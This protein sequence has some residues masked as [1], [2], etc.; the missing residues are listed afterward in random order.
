[1]LQGIAV[2][3]NALAI[4]EFIIQVLHPPAPPAFQMPSLPAP[5]IGRTQELETLATMPLNDAPVVLTPANYS[6]IKRRGQ[7][8]A[9]SDL[10][11]PVSAALS[12]VVCSGSVW[13]SLRVSPVQVATARWAS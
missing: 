13:S 9:G 12:S 11:P 1:M 5:L 3:R 6:V 2:G 10:R 8:A 7:N 4:G